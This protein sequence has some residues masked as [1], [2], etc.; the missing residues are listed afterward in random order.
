MATI[1]SIKIKFQINQPLLDKTTWLYYLRIVRELKEYLDGLFSINQE[2]GNKL[3]LSTSKVFFG[4]EKEKSPKLLYKFFKP[5]NKA[6]KKPK[7][8]SLHGS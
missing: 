5:K 3:S 1:T 4:N 2:I 7:N 8:K 6:F